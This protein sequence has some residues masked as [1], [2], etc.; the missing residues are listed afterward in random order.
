MGAGD[1]L[2]GRLPEG[3]DDIHAFLDR[4]RRASFRIGL[5]EELRVVWLLDQ[6]NRSAACPTTIDELGAWLA[7]LCCT[8]ARQQA[9]FAAEFAR[10]S[11]E[12]R[13]DDAA[14]VRAA[15]APSAAP[16]VAA[17]H[18][19]ASSD[20]WLLGAGTALLVAALVIVAA[21]LGRGGTAEPAPV[22]E[23]PV[24]TPTL[25]EDTPV[26]EALR[27]GAGQLA[28][29]A[30]LLLFLLWQRR[31]PQALARR[32]IAAATPG[33]AVGL[34]AARRLLFAP[35][36][37]SRDF[38][39]LRRH[40]EVP[41]SRIDV[42]RS[43]RA[44]LRAGGL[45]QVR[46]GTQRR[47]PDYLVMV[48]RASLDDHQGAL[49]D[50]VLRRFAEEQVPF[51]AYDF[52]GDPRRSRARGGGGP[53]GVADLAD[54]AA[55]HGEHPLIL[56]T[57]GDRFF[58][59]HGDQTHAWVDRLLAWPMTLLF[60]PKPRAEWG[61][62]ESRLQAMGFVVLPAT[63]DGIA[64]FAELLDAG[65]SSTTALPAPGTT[66]AALELL[67]V[68]PDRWVRQTAPSERETAQLLAALQAGLG[69]QAFELLCAAAVFPTV[70]AEV[71]L[72]LADALAGDG[73][74]L[75][76][77]DSFGR[78]ARL[79]WLRRGRMP[80]WLRLSLIARLGP[81]RE[82]AV[83]RLCL[84]LLRPRGP[85]Q[86]GYALEI[87]RADQHTWLATLLAVLRQDEASVLRDAVFLGFM[88]R[89]APDP[90]ALQ[91]PEAL[92]RLLQPPRFGPLEWFPLGVAALATFIL[93]RYDLTAGELLARAA[94]WA[95][96]RLALSSGAVEALR[97]AA[98]AAGAAALGMWH[99]AVM[100][101]RPQ[102]RPGWL[103]AARVAA[104]AAAIAAGV[105]LPGA[106]ALSF[107][108][109]L[110]AVAALTVLLTW[111]EPR[112]ALLA[113]VSPAALLRGGGWKRTSFGTAAWLLVFYAAYRELLPDAAAQPDALAL[114]VL[115]AALVGSL[116]LG[117]LAI[118][119]RLGVGLRVSAQAGLCSI[120]ALAAPLALSLAPGSAA[121]DTALL[122]T[123]GLAML[124]IAAWGASVA[125]WQCGRVR[126]G[127]VA[128]VAAVTIAMSGTALALFYGLDRLAPAPVVGP[129]ACALPVAWLYQWVIARRSRSAN[130]GSIT[131]TGRVL[132][133]YAVLLG[134]P[135]LATQTVLADQPA[136]WTLFTVLA[137]VMLLP[138]LHTALPGSFDAVEARR[139]EPGTAPRWQAWAGVPLLWLL[140]C[141]YSFGP[142]SFPPWS[143]KWLVVPLAAW[144]AVRFGRAG[145]APFATG[146]ALLLLSFPVGPL[147]IGGF[148][149][150][151][152]AAAV[153]YRLAA[154]PDYRAATFAAGRIGP[155]QLLF[156]TLAAATTVA[157][158]RGGVPMSFGGSLVPYLTLLLLLIGLSRARSR[159]LPWLL[160]LG[161]LL[162][163]AMRLPPL[164]TTAPDTF[165]WI[166]IAYAINDPSVLVGALLALYGPSYL[167]AHAADTQ[168]PLSLRWPLLLLVLGFVDVYFGLALDLGLQ[169]QTTVSLIGSSG[170]MVTAALIGLAYGRGVRWKVAGFLLGPCVSAAA[171]VIVDLGQGS[172][173]GAVG[174]LRYA[175]DVADLFQGA[176]VV[177]AFYWFGARCADAGVLATARAAPPALRDATL[178]ALRFAYMDIVLIVVCALLLVLRVGVPLYLI[179][180]TPA[181]GS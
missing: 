112:P 157:A 3:L 16:P 38:Q 173:R 171:I 34:Q 5:A 7:P 54:L 60:T 148:A 22:P 50:I 145:W 99:V 59:R 55:T 154:E 84:Q 27:R 58:A 41:S 132:A 170:L 1:R 142:L 163:M 167:T 85:G 74:P 6:L 156:V 113:P 168:Q 176:M 106:G 128:T 46:Y 101:E 35:G 138:A 126:T 48:D 72:W 103:L 127:W 9:L 29:L 143:A 39:A 107:G 141:S 32:F 10:W 162:G 31:R 69:L 153:V 111:L 63:P 68:R 131:A 15:D 114:P 91:A 147:Q 44:T 134:P 137:T 14:P 12:H 43:L 116:M 117:A 20:R 104:V 18:R 181:A 172:A 83:R 108:M 57:E 96:A 100:N 177:F 105:A 21:W 49:A 133:G 45:V 28:P 62:R 79:P 67:E 42:R 121:R 33:R 159:L 77:E 152:V 115:M 120:G 61:L 110:A 175:V 102:P 24:A 178:P 19:V 73:P 97:A 123:Q 180:G 80:D 95:A 88:H 64:R 136:T 90:L 122:A 47:L 36:R 89:R 144:W 51:S 11:H 151:F 70:H 160:T 179:Q 76:D 166:T 119:H 40:H 26:V 17:V 135:L 118:G 94:R 52:H 37:Q 2:S 165:D 130:D 146:T 174:A 92:T 129:L 164:A 56:F 87:A 86:E 30:V 155:R 161:L 82:A 125:L 140:C 25:V 66:T 98:S 65:P 139:R 4:L 75:L 8:N 81:A 93:W 71:T 169:N 150:L 23:T 158:P 124:G 13:P 149:G 109:A 53:H 78:L